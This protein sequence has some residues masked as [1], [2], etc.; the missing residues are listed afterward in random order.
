MPLKEWLVCPT[1][2]CDDVNV[3]TIPRADHVWIELSCSNCP[4]G[5][6]VNAYPQQPDAP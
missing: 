4:E 3:H 6:S 5:H 2:G 1:C